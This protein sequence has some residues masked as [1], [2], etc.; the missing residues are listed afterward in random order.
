MTMPTRRV[1]S[2]HHSAQPA[3]LKV[4]A[5]VGAAHAPHLRRHLRAARRHIKSPVNDLHVILVNDKTMSRLHEQFMGM[6]G[7][8]DV[9]TFPLDLDPKGRPLSAEI[10]VNVNHARRESKKRNLPLKNE[11]L[12]YALHGMLHLSGYDD[13]TDRDFRRM[14]TKEDQ[15]LQQLGIGP[16]F[17]PDVQNSRAGPRARL[18]LAASHRSNPKRRTR[19]GWT[20]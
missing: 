13:R 20:K 4:T 16:I 9:L 7:P 5:Q 8:T 1:G 19:K 14:H 6:K 12:L 2:A 18:P 15:I 3:P 10:Y 11:L 17:A